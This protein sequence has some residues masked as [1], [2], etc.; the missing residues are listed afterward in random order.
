MPKS[1]KKEKVVVG[2]G[3]SKIGAAIAEDL[4]IKCQHVGVV[5]EVLRGTYCVVQ[6][7][8]TQHNPV[9]SL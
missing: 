8:H 6:E 1:G 4:G 9:T 2:V 7:G 5:P 3:D